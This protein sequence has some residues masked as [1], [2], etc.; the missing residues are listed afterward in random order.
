MGVRESGVGASLR[1]LL[2]ARQLAI[3]QSSLGL[4]DW[5]LRLI[6][7]RIEKILAS[8]EGNKKTFNSP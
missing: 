3:E 6:R 2:V 5:Y 7:A 8:A 4:Y 1:L